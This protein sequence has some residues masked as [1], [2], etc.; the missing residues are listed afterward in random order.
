MGVEFDR[1]A[2]KLPLNASGLGLSSARSWNRDGVLVK[3]GH[4]QI[5]Q[6]HTAVSMWIR[7][8]PPLAFGSQFRQLRLEPAGPVEEVFGPISLHPFLEN[9]DMLGL[10]HIAHWHLMRA[11][12]IFDR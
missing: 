2:D 4:P 7:A 5:A 6:H 11:E 9:L 12:G 3:I 10:L 1:V 8:H